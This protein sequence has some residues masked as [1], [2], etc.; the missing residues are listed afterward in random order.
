[1]NVCDDCDLRGYS[2]ELCMV[3]LRHCR[4]HP[5]GRAG[6]PAARVAARTAGGVALGVS[7]S[8]VVAT[9]ASFVGGPSWFYA[10]MGWLVATGGLLGGGWGLG[11]GLAAE[12]ALAPR[13][14]PA[15]PRY[16]RRPPRRLAA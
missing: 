11:R 5:E 12:R 4:K 2:R 8:L 14:A 3:H 15:P 1:M 7:A 16:H 10:V 9:A 13:P 6:S